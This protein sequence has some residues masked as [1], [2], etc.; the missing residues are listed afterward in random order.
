VLVGAAVV[1]AVLVVTVEG[2][3]ELETEP[4]TTRM[5]AQFLNSS[6]PGPTDGSGA[7]GPLMSGMKALKSGHLLSEQAQPQKLNLLQPR[8]SKRLR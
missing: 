2:A 7:L 6:K 5:S 3:D 1:I 4:P 8:L